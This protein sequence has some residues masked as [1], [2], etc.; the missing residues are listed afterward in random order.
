MARGASE[1]EAGAVVGGGNARSP[2]ELIVLPDLLGHRGIKGGTQH[3]RIEQR[4][5]VRRR[6]RK[7][8]NGQLGEVRHFGAHARPRRPSPAH[9]R[10]VPTAGKGLRYGRSGA[11]VQ[12]SELRRRGGLRLRHGRHLA[13]RDAFIVRL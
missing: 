8:E 2:D 6:L 12:A 5:R 13:R 10:Q 11:Y 3:G 7:L 4:V 9:Q 1:R